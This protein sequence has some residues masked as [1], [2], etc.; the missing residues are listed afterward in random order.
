MK[1]LASEA[2]IIVEP[3][4]RILGLNNLIRGDRTT[5]AESDHTQSVEVTLMDRLPMHVTSQ[6]FAKV[7]WGVVHL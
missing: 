4:G 6:T 1:S 2:V 7:L 5:K 3:S